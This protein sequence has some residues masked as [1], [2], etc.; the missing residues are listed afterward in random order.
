MKS[1][2]Q[3]YFLKLIAPRPTFAFDMTDAERAVMKKHVDYWIDFMNKGAVVVFGPVFDP[4]GVYGMGVV[5]AES[6]QEVKTFMANDPAN[7]INTY[8]YFPMKAV[9]PQKKL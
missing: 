1:E 5:T 7:G 8:E 3:Y 4:N 6:E 9:V 2:K